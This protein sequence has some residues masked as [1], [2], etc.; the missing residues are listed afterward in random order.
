MNIS[1]NASSEQRDHFSM[2]MA[3]CHTGC[4]KHCRVDVNPDGELSR[5]PT[6]K[7]MMAYLFGGRRFPWQVVEQKI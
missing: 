7:D 3:G 1:V 5:R 2:E 6:R 4:A